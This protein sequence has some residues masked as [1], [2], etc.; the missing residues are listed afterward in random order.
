[1]W[2]EQAI[3]REILRCA[4]EE[5]LAEWGWDHG[6]P[7]LRLLLVRGGI[8]TNQARPNELVRLLLD[9]LPVQGLFAL[10]IDEHGVLPGLGMLAHSEPLAVVQTLE[11]GVL[12][13]V[14]WVVVPTGAAQPGE[15]ILDL[16]V[17]SAETARFEAEILA[18]NLEILPLGAGQ[19]AELV[20]K[21]RRGIDV[22]FGPGRGK[23]VTVFGGS[24][25]LIVD[26]RQRPLI[27]PPNDD[28]RTTLLAAWQRE[29]G[30]VF[31]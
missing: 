31:D 17:Q 27:L 23:K 20:L 30:V 3:A 7:A 22:G 14:G 28:E 4:A 13:D 8:F 19:R 21:P 10:A 2:L 18:G 24:L 29:M 5:T 25:G 16:V 12:N 9:V 15:K 1:M 11:A 26:A 6:I